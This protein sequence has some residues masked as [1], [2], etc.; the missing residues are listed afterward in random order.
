MVFGVLF[1]IAG[2]ISTIYGY[3]LN[4]S[5]EAQLS[6][7]W[8]TGRTNPGTIFIVVGI[9]AAI[10]GIVIAILSYTN[11]TS[12]ANESKTAIEERVQKRCPSC[13][14]IVD[15]NSYFC[16]VCGC[17]LLEKAPRTDNRLVT[18]NKTTEI[19]PEKHANEPFE[20]E[21]EQTEFKSRVKKKGF[22]TPQDM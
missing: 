3:Y 5:F 19:V 8:N 17:S 16:S 2:L 15:E 20:K 11:K 22:S 10:L 1:V 18:E 9:A 14:A 7:L 4:N 21:P 13:G 6:Y 12:D